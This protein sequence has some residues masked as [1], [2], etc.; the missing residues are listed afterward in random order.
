MALTVRA[1]ITVSGGNWAFDRWPP[2][3]LRTLWL[4]ETIATV[5]PVTYRPQ[6]SPRVCDMSPDARA[7][8]DMTPMDRAMPLCVG[9]LWAAYLARREAEVRPSLG[10]LLDRCVD[11][12]TRLSGLRQL[13]SIGRAGARGTYA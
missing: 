10:H 5:D 7:L 9:L 13:G 1:T 6:A 2:D 12:W 4:T 3:M 8:L 11:A